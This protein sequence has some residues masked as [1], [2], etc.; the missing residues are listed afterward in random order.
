MLFLLYPNFYKYRFF[1]KDIKDEIKYEEIIGY[2]DYFSL[3][4]TI[5]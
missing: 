4:C 2:L 1:Y 3:K 5:N